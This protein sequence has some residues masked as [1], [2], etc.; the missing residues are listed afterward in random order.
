M[1]AARRESE[2]ASAVDQLVEAYPNSI[3]MAEFRA[4]MYAELNRETK[5]FDG[6]VHLLC[7]SLSVQ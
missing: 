2:F 4:A 1:L 5:Y 3:G 7:E 6:L